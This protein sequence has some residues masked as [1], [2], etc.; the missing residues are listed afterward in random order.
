MNTNH[1][2]SQGI[3]LKPC[4]TF[5]KGTCRKQMAILP[6]GKF[7][8]FDQRVQCIPMWSHFLCMFAPLKKKKTTAVQTVKKPALHFLMKK[9]PKRHE[10]W[11]I[12]T[13]TDSRH[14]QTAIATAGTRD[15]DTQPPDRRAQ[16]NDFPC[17]LQCSP[18]APY[19]SGTAMRTDAHPWGHEENY[20]G[21]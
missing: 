8:L 19:G 11:S 4:H 7:D 14:L 15:E 2:I 17:R 13:I 16:A 9:G 12:Q 1:K 20:Q 3:T 10:T 18:V 6:S 21:R 5:F